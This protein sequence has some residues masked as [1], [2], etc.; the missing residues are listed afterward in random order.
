MSCFGKRNSLRVVGE[1]RRAARSKANAPAIVQ[2]TASQLKATIVDIS[3]TGARLIATDHPPSRQ[4]VQ[5][6]VNGLWIFG[7]IVW[8]RG[9]AF[10]LKFDEDLHDY[11]SSEIHEAVE[12]ATALNHDFDREAVLAPLLNETIFNQQQEMSRAA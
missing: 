5:L 2:T 6:Y 4:D 11:S 10:G 1:K 9:K 7:R 8:R 12:E 3:A